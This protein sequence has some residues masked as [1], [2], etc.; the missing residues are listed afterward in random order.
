MDK[1]FVA[2][3]IAA[4]RGRLDWSGR[5][6]TGFET[7]KGTAAQNSLRQWVWVIPGEGPKRHRQHVLLGAYRPSVSVG[8]MKDGKQIFKV[9]GPIRKRFPQPI[10][11]NGQPWF[12]LL[13]RSQNN[14]SFGFNEI[15]EP[16]L[17]RLHQPR[18]Q[19][20]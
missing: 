17:G 8:Q 6:R 18:R 1:H 15:K 11:L 19:G 3:H 9:E 5:A 13:Y 16:P 10:V 2:Y 7:S 12:E 20:R 14:F 4:D